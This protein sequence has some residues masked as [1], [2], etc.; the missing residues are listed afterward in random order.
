MKRT[1]VAILALSPVFAFAQT[2][3]PAQPRS[4]QISE[5]V[6][7]A[8]LHAAAP[9]ADRTSATASTYRV[10]TGV[11]PPHVVKSVE[12]VT[13]TGQKQHTTGVDQKV[14]LSLNVDETGKPCNLAVAQ[15]A[16]PMLDQDVLA[17]VARYRFKPGMLD[18]QA[19]AVPVRLEVI[20]PAGTNY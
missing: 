18:G 7:P 6:V 13:A 4:T 19:T 15:S 1:L 14:V 20:I 2:S 11:I 10:S 3:S 5:V 9:A 8:D 17:T 16:G 12:F